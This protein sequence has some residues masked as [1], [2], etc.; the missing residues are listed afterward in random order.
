MGKQEDPIEVIRNK[1]NQLPEKDANG[2]YNRFSGQFLTW[3]VGGIAGS[4]NDQDIRKL[5]D[6]LRIG[7]EKSFADYIG[8][9]ILEEIA[10]LFRDNSHYYR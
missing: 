8:Q 10:K 5:G 6:V 3:L 4:S 9:K 1:L 2:N 7:A